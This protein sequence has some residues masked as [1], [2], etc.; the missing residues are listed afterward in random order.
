MVTPMSKA[1]LID[2][3]KVEMKMRL[4]NSNIVIGVPG[5]YGLEFTK[6]IMA[7]PMI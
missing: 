5:N 3:I 4:L 7:Y 2:T 1:A 6:K